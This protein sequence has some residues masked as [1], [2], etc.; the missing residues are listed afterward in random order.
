MIK[1]LLLHN[2][3]RRLARL[4]LRDSL[5]QGIDLTIYAI[6]HRNDPDRRVINI[7]RAH[8]TLR[9][10]NDTTDDHWPTDCAFKQFALCK[11]VANRAGTA[12]RDLSMTDRVT[13]ASRERGCLGSGSARRGASENRDIYAL[14]A[15]TGSYPP[16]YSYRNKPSIQLTIL[17]C[18]KWRNTF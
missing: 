15:N 10:F 17:Y 9:L 7:N 12:V 18:C 14:I 5:L 13:P 11:Q 4:L 3:F 16:D 8:S 1:L 6:R 2:I